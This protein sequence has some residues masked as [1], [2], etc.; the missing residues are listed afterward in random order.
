[1]F[2]ASKS[3]FTVYNH[4]VVS[5]YEIGRLLR[6]EKSAVY[7]YVWIPVRNTGLNL[8]FVN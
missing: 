5:L 4:N 2:K 7:F 1:M 8:T 6:V 3:V